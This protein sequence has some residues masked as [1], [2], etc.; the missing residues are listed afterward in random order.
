MHNFIKLKN[1]LSKPAAAV[2]NLNNIYHSNREKE[3]LLKAYEV[4]E[5][6]SKTEV[7]LCI[8]K[9]QQDDW[10]EKKMLHVLFCDFS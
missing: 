6:I 1:Y 9:E 8:C 10:M 3:K 2:K 5:K 7:I 4:N